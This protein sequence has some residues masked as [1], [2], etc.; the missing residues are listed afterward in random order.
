MEKRN[1]AVSLD[2][3][4]RWYKSGNEAL[5]TLA[6]QVF[7]KE[8][9]EEPQSF[10]EL[11]ALMG[12][13]SISSKIEIF[14]SKDIDFNKNLNNNMFDLVK[15]NIIAKYLNKGWRPHFKEAKYYIARFEGYCKDNVMQLEDDLYVAKNI[16]SI[17]PG[18][19]YFKTPELTK[20]A[21]WLMQN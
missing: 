12:I 2:E 19:V 6:L 7:T 21:F 14:P 8:E 20:K 11:L 3:A 5:K 1:I 9:L 13:A 15:L 17:I 10:G 18:V 16:G 4:K